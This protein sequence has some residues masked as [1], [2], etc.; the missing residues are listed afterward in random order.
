MPTNI[1]KSLRKYLM[2]SKLESLVRMENTRETTA[3]KIT[4]AL[5]CPIY[6]HPFLP[7]AMSY[8]SNMT[9]RLSRPAV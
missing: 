5:I 6:R 2:R 1:A 4:N 9:S 3:E 7:K 8:A